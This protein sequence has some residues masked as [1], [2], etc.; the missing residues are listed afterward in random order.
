VSA[1]LVIASVTFSVMGLSSSM[2]ASQIE[3]STYPK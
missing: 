3:L 1:A 2:E